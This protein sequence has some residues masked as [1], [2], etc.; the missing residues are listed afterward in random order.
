MD[1]AAP[2]DSFAAPKRT[3]VLQVLRPDD[4]PQRQQQQ[5][6]PSAVPAIS[7]APNPAPGW[8]FSAP[9]YAQEEEERASANASLSQQQQYRAGTPSP[10]SPLDLNVRTYG[11]A[12]VATS[13]V[14]AY[15]WISAETRYGTWWRPAWYV[16]ALVQAVLAGML[17]CAAGGGVRRGWGP[18][19]GATLLPFAAPL[20]FAALLEIH[21]AE[22]DGGDAQKLWTV[23]AGRAVAVLSLLS[24]GAAAGLYWRARGRKA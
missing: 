6:G 16:V 1:S 21:L 5:Q 2:T 22:P 3:A 11:L 12:L 23:W 9:S 4:E 20:I 19:L 17:L 8:R 18:P 10:L 7:S 14:F 24:A 15:L 13:L